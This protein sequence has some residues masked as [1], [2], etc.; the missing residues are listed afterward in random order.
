MIIGDEDLCAPSF[1]RTYNI[2]DSALEELDIH[3]EVTLGSII[4]QAIARTRTNVLRWYI[5]QGMSGTATQSS[6][7]CTWQ[8]AERNV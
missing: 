1:D 8:S 5:P 7:S 6:L 2:R 3:Q 4:E